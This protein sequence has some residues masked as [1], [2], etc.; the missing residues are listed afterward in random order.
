MSELDKYIDELDTILSWCEEL[1][2]VAAL[3]INQNDEAQR[4]GKLIKVFH[5]GLAN[6]R[7]A[8]ADGDLARII[9]ICKC[10]TDLKLP[11]GGDGGSFFRH[12]AALIYE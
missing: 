3:E 9:E 4:D 8:L 5:E 10:N 7:D 6:L 11:G 2:R 12:I 1:G